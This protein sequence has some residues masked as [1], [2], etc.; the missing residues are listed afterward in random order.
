MSLV[1][2]SC[3]E[4]SVIYRRPSIL[5]HLNLASLPS[6]VHMQTELSPLPKSSKDGERAQREIEIPEEADFKAYSPFGASS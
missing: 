6:H 5:E 4:Q 1:G 2:N 3:I